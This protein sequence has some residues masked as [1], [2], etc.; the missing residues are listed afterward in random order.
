MEGINQPFEGGIPDSSPALPLPG[1]KPEDA[2]VAQSA[3]FLRRAI[4]FLIDFFI[5]EILYL[6]VLIAGFL[7]IHFSTGEEG[8]LLSD[9]GS[10]T[11][12]VAP[13][14]AAWFCLFLGYFTYFHAHGGQ[15]P[16]KMLI[17]IRVV[18]AGGIPLSP[19]RALVRSFGYFLSSFFFGFGFFISIFERKKRALHDL[20]ARTEVVLS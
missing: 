3:G 18:A 9:E 4:A 2:A 20:L 19:F 15:T 14:I 13:F 16:A 8:L 6:S 11:P 5:I 1:E 17:R 10:L 7:A 12:L